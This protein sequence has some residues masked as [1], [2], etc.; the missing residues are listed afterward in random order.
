[1]TLPSLWF[2]AGSISGFLAVVAGAYGAHGLNSDEISINIFNT[3][4]NFH[5]WHSLALLSV[6]WF[7]ETRSKTDRGK[8]QAKWGNCSGF[9]FLIGIILF[10]GTLYSLAL[11]T[12]IPIDGLAPSGGIALMAGWIILA[13]AAMR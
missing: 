13:F 10:C 5:M 6:A 8:L 1:M 9:L 3:A 12:V 7:I 11:N 2:V 4:F